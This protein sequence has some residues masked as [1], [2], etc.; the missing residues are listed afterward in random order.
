[1]A[2]H[3]SSNKLSNFVRIPGNTES[4]VFALQN[5]FFSVLFF[6]ISNTIH[7]F[8]VVFG[9]IHDVNLAL[10]VPEGHNGGPLQCPQSVYIKCSFDVLDNDLRLLVI[11]QFIILFITF[12][13]RIIIIFC[14]MQFCPSCQTNLV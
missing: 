3:I 14:F 1:M 11:A 9:E 2:V 12:N 4:F 10:I 6:F 13:I 8:L 7:E 5:D